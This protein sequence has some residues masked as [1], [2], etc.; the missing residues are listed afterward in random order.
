MLSMVPA[1]RAFVRAMLGDCPRLE[2]ALVIASEHTT[3]SM[4]HAHSDTIAVAVT[5][6]PGSARIAVTDHGDGAWS[7]ELAVPGEEE[8]SGRGLW[9][10]AAYADTFGHDLD[11]TG[12]TMWAELT[13]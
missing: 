7:R 5:V 13:W 10:I 1:I 12:Q 9:I 11:P 4:R 8:E 3:N 2:D 6:G